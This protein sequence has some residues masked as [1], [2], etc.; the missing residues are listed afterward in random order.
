MGSSGWLV[1]IITMNPL[2]MAK[3]L[4]G[5]TCSCFPVEK[6]NWCLLDLTTHQQSKPNTKKGS[7]IMQ[8]TCRI[9]SGNR[10][11]QIDSKVNDITKI[12]HACRFL[13]SWNATIHSKELMWNPMRET[14]ALRCSKPPKPIN[15]SLIWL[16]TFAVITNWSST[17]KCGYHYVLLYV[18][19]Q[20]HMCL[21]FWIWA[22]LEFDTPL[23]RMEMVDSTRNPLVVKGAL[24]SRHG[25][26]CQS[27]QLRPKCLIIFFPF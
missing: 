9:S 15:I 7:K 6:V 17:P 1:I 27:F 25:C 20:V 13:L 18:F 10:T 2:V 3:R 19:R 12:M 4:S 11:N 5:A 8:I 26:Y 14:V 16:R 23:E 24:N 22:Y 21:C